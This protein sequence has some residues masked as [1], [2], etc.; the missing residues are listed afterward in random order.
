MN[1]DGR[2][3]RLPIDGLLDLHPFAPRDVKSVVDEYVHAAHAAGLMEIRIIHGRGVGTQRGI[4]QAALE[5]HAL[6]ESFADA[7]DSH[8]GATV[9][10]L[11]Q[12]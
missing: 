10:V 9:A 3:H 4:V 11:R 7:P 5:R 6:V 8:L 12:A 2:A 1:D